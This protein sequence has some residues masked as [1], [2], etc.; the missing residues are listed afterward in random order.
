M[1]MDST[2][3]SHIAAV[4]K[5]FALLKEATPFV[6][7]GLAAQRKRAGI[8]VFFENDVPQHVGRKRRLQQRL[9]GHITA[10]DYTATYAFKMARRH[11]G[12]PVTYNTVGGR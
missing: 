12:L 3:A 9:R 11:L 10:S 5:L 1:L 6:E 8:Y 4:P 7:K 2:F